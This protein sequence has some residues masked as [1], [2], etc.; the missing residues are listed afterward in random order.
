M[1]RN[2]VVQVRIQQVI[3]CSLG[4]YLNL[5][6]DAI[7]VGCGN[8]H[9]R[10]EHTIRFGTWRSY[11]LRS[12]WVALRLSGLPIYSERCSL[13]NRLLGHDLSHAWDDGI[14]KNES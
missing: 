3:I 6:N 10:V 7:T 5:G 1:L 9:Q 2:S 14:L 11:K 8:D 13:Q 4:E 12:P